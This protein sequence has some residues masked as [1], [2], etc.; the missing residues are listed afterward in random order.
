MSHPSIGPRMLLLLT[1][2][3]WGFAFVAQRAGMAHV[4]PF[5]FNSIRFLLGALTLVPFLRI[6]RLSAGSATP[7]W[8]GR[9]VAVASVISG[10]VLFAGAS[11]QQAG[12]VY[13]TAGKAGF[14]TGLYVIMVPLLGLLWRHRPGPFTWTGAGLAVVGLYLLSIQEGL[15][16][17]RGDLL[18]LLGAVC[19]AVHV[20]IVGQYARAVGP[21]RLAFLQF[22][23]CGLLSFLVALLIEP[24]SRSGIQDAAGPLLYGGFL[25]VGT[26]F[27]LQVIAQKH[28]PPS[29]AAIIMSLE[30]VFAAL[31]GWLLLH[32]MLSPRS[33]AG[34]ALMLIGI[35][36]SQIDPRPVAPPSSQGGGTWQHPNEKAVTS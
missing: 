32:E 34:C 25:S 33:L 26:A 23:V 11:L 18:V 35:V 28:V 22:L 4:G 16:M 12:I 24:V 17:A 8:S 31:G 7:P 9:R 13:T 20:L 27:T 5:T 14:I 36:V 21:L 2:A 6:H 15:S 29:H 30:T 19:W 1:S 10:T 3:I